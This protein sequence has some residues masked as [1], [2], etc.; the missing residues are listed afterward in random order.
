[1]MVVG[2]VQGAQHH[3]RIGSRCDY[4]NIVLSAEKVTKFLFSDISTRLRSTTSALPFKL[5]GKVLA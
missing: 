1:M 4:L 3:R 5:D 2:I